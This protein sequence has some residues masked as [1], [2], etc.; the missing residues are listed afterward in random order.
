M[1]LILHNE[2][3]TNNSLVFICVDGSEN[4][5]RAFEW[6]YAHCYRVEQTVGIVHV[7]THNS[8]KSKRRS[9]NTVEGFKHNQSTDI[10]QKYLSLC[11]TRGMKTKIYSKPKE[12]TESVGHTIC[13]LIK[14][15]HPSL[16]VIGQRG[17]GALKRTLFGSVSEYVVNHGHIPIIIVPP[18][19]KDKDRNP[20]SRN[21]VSRSKSMS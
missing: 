2:E 7:H 18:L 14:E 19:K 6:F 1:S 9:V 16:I 3:V 17:I 11:V 5:I 12:K 20:V 10:I 8:P 21:A 13:T 15:N 4:A